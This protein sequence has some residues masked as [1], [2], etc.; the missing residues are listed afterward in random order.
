MKPGDAVLNGTT[1]VSTRIGK[2]EEEYVLEQRRKAAVAVA[3]TFARDA[4]DCAELLA[5]LGLRPAEGKAT[6][7]NVQA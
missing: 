4:Q 7:L 1:S 6:G 3:G 5:M 2:A